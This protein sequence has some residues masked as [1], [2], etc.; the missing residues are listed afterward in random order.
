[1]NF[2]S[3]LER[4]CEWLNFPNLY[5]YMIVIYLV[6]LIIKLY[7]PLYYL[8]YLSLD[9][10]MIMKGQIWRIFTFIFYPPTSSI[11]IILSL[12]VIYI[13][14]PILKT[15]TMIWRPFKFNLFMLIGYL[16]QIAGAFFAYFVLGINVIIDPTYYFFSIILAF[17]LSF[18][19]A[20]FYLYFLIPIKAKY[21]AYFEIVIYAFIF[22][23]AGFDDRLAIVC[24]A[25]NVF[26][27]F[28]LWK[29][30]I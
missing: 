5:Q 11:S 22:I 24:S 29:N 15:L 1:M 3:K 21:L 16:S 13:D 14:Y 2:L 9:V 25:V 18:P 26:V 28:V 20:M 27:F 17:A 12:I 4:K 30:K 19:D 23:T 6:G 10:S 7:N 8:Y